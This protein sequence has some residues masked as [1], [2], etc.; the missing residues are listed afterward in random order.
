MRSRQW[1]W[2]G[3][4]ALAG[5]VACTTRDLPLAAAP[6]PVEAPVVPGARVLYFGE[7]FSE[8]QQALQQASSRESAAPTF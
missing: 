5:V 2:I 6:A 7:Q 1:I 3:V 4:T 8:A